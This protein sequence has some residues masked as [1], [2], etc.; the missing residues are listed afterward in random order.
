MNSGSYY[1]IMGIMINILLTGCHSR[2]APFQEPRHLAIVQKQGSSL[3]V[4]RIDNTIV[5]REDSSSSGRKNFS[6]FLIG[7]RDTASKN[8]LAEAG[9]REK[10]FQYD[11]QKDWCGLIKGDSI[12]PVFFQEKP[13]LDKD[14]KQAVLVFET[15]AGVGPDTLIYKDTYGSGGTVIFV[16]N[17]N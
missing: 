16:L 13:G 1:L 14:L 17:R 15:P 3:V 2:P 4:D 6:S 12:R 9:K 5:M 10:Y 11:M 8:D 7:W